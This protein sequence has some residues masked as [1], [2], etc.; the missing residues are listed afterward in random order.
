MSAQFR[1]KVVS[2]VLSVLKIR[3][4]RWRLDS[5]L[6]LPHLTLLI[7]LQPKFPAKISIAIDFRSALKT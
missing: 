4:Q 2:S 3:V 6:L 1:N 5:S 7:S